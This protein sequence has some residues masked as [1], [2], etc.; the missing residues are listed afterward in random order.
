MPLPRSGTLVSLSPYDYNRASVASFSSD[1]NESEDGVCGVFIKGDALLSPTKYPTAPHSESASSSKVAEL[2]ERKQRPIPS[3]DFEP[4]LNQS[5]DIP[6]AFVEGKD[7]LS[8]TQFHPA[9]HSHSESETGSMAP[10]DAVSAGITE[11]KWQCTV[12]GC[13]FEAAIRRSPSPTPTLLVVEEIT[14]PK[15]IH[16]CLMEQGISVR[17]YGFNP[18]NTG[19]PIYRARKRKC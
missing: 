7:F 9:M 1:T 15:E 13:N 16:E 10:L 4:R 14:D 2:A 17:D 18:V 12:P 8:P 11:R 3:H 19:G 6:G 5:S